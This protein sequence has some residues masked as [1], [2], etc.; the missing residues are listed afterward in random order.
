VAEARKY[1]GLAEVP[2]K[3]HNPMI[4]NWLHE[5]KAW[6]KDDET[7]WCGVFVAHCLR[8]GGRAGLASGGQ[9]SGCGGEGQSG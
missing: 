8:I 1:I 4:L 9:I 7:P 2:G 3:N 6:W 5:L